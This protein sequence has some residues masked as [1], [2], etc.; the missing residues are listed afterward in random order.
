M[1]DILGLVKSVGVHEDRGVGIHHGLLTGEFPA[2]HDTY[3][4]IGING[5]QSCAGMTN[6][7]RCVVSGVAVMQTSGGQVKYT[8]KECHEHV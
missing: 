3:G 1:A 7:Q 2:G 6:Q 4:Q 5:Q 8:G